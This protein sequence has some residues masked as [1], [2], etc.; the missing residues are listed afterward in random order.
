[1]RNKK[2]LN[3]SGFFG[4]LFFERGIWILYLLSLD[5]SM[6]E[7]GV[8]QSALNLTMLILE[9]PAGYLSD[10]IGRR[11]TMLI[12]HSF[13]ILYLAVFLG[14]STFP[15]L[16]LGHI[17]YGAGLA[18]IS[19]SDE[20]L[21]YDSLKSDGKKE[22]YGKAIGFYNAI[23]IISIGIATGIGGFLQGYSWNYVFIGGIIAQCV[24]LFSVFLL[25]EIDIRQSDTNYVTDQEVGELGNEEKPGLV[26]EMMLFLHFNNRI[27][28]LIVSLAVFFAIA[29]V[30]IM[31]SQ[32]LF[33]EK[34]VSVY[35]ISLL[36]ASVSIVQAIVSLFSHQ[37]AEKLSQ[38]RVLLYSFILIGIAY[39]MVASDGVVF[40]IV[41]FAIIAVVYEII[42]PISSKVIN[43]EIPSK[44]RATILSMISLFTS[45]VMFVAFPLIGYL[46]DQFDSSTI[47]AVAGLLSII[48]SILGA[49]TF[50]RLKAEDAEDLG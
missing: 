17:F 48:V 36:Y 22:L 21:L 31:F 41:A 14:F 11:K 3:F 30:F 34:G 27:K 28:F 24:A 9:V 23:L 2:I 6:V 33:Y 39:L 15:F 13:L 29:S 43:D 37:L 42:Y 7:I 8:I 26:K 49:N 25:E 32:E 19:G 18:L 35:A 16:I 10:R 46:S 50:F 44:M 40:L 20:A 38:G 4:N 47:L 1:M 12:G 5:F 45:Y